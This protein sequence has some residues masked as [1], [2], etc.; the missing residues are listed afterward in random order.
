MLKFPVLFTK[1]D[2]D[3]YVV[4]FRD[5][6][7]AL[8]QGDTLEEARG[9]ARD[10][11]ITAMDFYIEDNRRVPKASPVEP[12]EELIGLPLSI[13]AKIMLLNEMLEKRI[14]TTDLAK[15]M[16]IKPQEV[17]SLMDLHHTTKIDTLAHAFST[18]GRHLELHLS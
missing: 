8:T 16:Q 15:A 17:T 3:G 2:S 5:I 10:A 9:A 13:S 4:T 18:L 1:Y 14:Q 7:E 11:L 12:G 6:P